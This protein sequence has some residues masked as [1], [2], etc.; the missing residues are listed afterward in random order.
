MGAGDGLKVGVKL[1]N[2]LEEDK[3]VSGITAVHGS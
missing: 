2:D 3:S 1:N